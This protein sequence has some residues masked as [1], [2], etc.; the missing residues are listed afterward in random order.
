MHQTSQRHDHIALCTVAGGLWFSDK[1]DSHSDPEYLLKCIHSSVCIIIPFISLD[2]PTFQ[3]YDFE[4]L[5]NVSTT[6]NKNTH[7]SAQ[8]D[9]NTHSVE[10]R[11]VDK[12]I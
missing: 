10:N 1:I 4:L 6:T 7:V 12:E 2:C 5:T 3:R 11:L 9:A 8:K